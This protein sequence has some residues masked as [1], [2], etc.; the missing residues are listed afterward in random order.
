MQKEKSISHNIQRRSRDI[1]GPLYEVDGDE[2]YI[3]SI[4]Q[5]RHARENDEAGLN[6]T[7]SSNQS[8]KRKQ[9]KSDHINPNKERVSLVKVKEDNKEIVEGHVSRPPED[10][11]SHPVGR[12]I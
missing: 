4:Q 6:S 12:A 5:Q 9:L 7:N 3:E 2:S 1:S 11:G 8:S 10:A